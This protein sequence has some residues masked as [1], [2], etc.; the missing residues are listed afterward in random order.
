VARANARPL[1][2]PPLVRRALQGALR[3]LD[4]RRQVRN[5][6]MFVVLVGSLLATALFFQALAGRGEAPAGFI[7]AVAAWLWFTVL[8]ANFAGGLAE[9]RG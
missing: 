5:P 8:F 9:G 2:D 7:G 3:K 6:V 1:F 4:P